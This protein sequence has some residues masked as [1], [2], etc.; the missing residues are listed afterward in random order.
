M[1]AQELNHGDDGGRTVI[2]ASAFNINVECL[3]LVLRRVPDVGMVDHQGMT[4]EEVGQT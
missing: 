4:P 2:H 1:G 3:G